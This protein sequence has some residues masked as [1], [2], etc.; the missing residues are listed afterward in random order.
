MTGSE[1]EV[2]LAAGLKF[3]LQAGPDLGIDIDPSL[4]IYLELPHASLCRTQ[5]RSTGKLIQLK[6]C[7]KLK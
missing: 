6:C 7:M 3:S 5:E 1:T 2:G 4:A